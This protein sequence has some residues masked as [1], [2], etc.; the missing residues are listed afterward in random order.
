MKKILAPLWH[1][2]WE[3][4]SI[5]SWVVNVVLAF[6]LI[7][8]IV[9]P[10]LGFAFSTE[11]PVVAVVSKSMEHSTPDFDDWWKGKSRQYA[12]FNI[13]K[14]DF[15]SFTLKEGFK[16]GDIMLLRGEK[17]EKL[18]PGDVIVFKGGEKDPIIHRL[19]E[20]TKLGE[21]YIFSTMGDNNN[22]QL[23]YER[24]ITEER[25]VGKTILRVPYLGYVKII[26][27]FLLSLVKGVM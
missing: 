18:K 19:V 14:S 23:T 4:N 1:F 13:T 27:T 3:D 20:K 10:G 12:Q 15:E 24:N 21:R 7:K 25:I 22:N 16:K 2:I 26:F 8:F 11:S 5:L 6:I 17:P 9:Y